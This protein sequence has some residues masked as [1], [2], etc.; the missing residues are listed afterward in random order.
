M[1]H[2][3]HEIEVADKSGLEDDGDVAGV[4]ELDGVGWVLSSDFVVLDVDVNFE[5]L[6]VDDKQEDQNSGHQV[7][8]VG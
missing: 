4:E 8:E 6:E 2:L 7:G 5:S 1:E 3:W